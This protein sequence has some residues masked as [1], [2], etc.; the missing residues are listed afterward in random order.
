MLGTLISV[1]ANASPATAAG[2]GTDWK[3][4]VPVGTLVLGFGLKWLQDSI[5]ERHRR[6]YEQTLRREQRFDQLRARRMD[7]ERANLLA[8]QPLVVSFM[9]TA[10]KAYK[11]KVKAG[12][13]E[14]A[15]DAFMPQTTEAIDA[16]KKAMAQVDEAVRQASAA[17][18]PL[19][20]RLHTVEVT[21]ALNFL[22]DVVWEALAAETVPHM[23]RKWSM[24]DSPHS[25]LHRVM[26]LTI[27]HLEDEYLQLGDPEIR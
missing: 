12:T 6:N 26:G 13:F 27:K 24:V 22:I 20:S 17:I 19:Q 7:A 16:E 18:I 4:L 14:R 8:L 9:Q 15:G 21:A 23:M 10:T 11:H 1:A 3:W 5:T 2:T 25:E